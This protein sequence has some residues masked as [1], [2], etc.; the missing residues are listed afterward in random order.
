MGKNDKAVTN[1]YHQRKN[2]LVGCPQ[3]HSVAIITEKLAKGRNLKEKES[4]VFRNVY[5]AWKTSELK[6]M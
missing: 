6:L 1:N 4:F 5:I 3:Q 2:K